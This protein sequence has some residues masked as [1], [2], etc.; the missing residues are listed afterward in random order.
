MSLDAQ[1][2]CSLAPG[3][4][5]AEETI[6]DAEQAATRVADLAEEALQSGTFGI[7]GLLMGLDGRVIAQARNAV[8]HG[9]SVF[10]P[11]AHVERQLVDWYFATRNSL[12]PPPNEIV[13]VSSLDP[14]AM[15][16]GAILKAGFKVIAV[17]EDP[18]SGIHSPRLKL[19]PEDT[20]KEI[21][22]RFRIFRRAHQNSSFVPGFP[23][24]L[25]GQISDVTWGRSCKAFLESLEHVRSLVSGEPGRGRPIVPRLRG[26]VE[27]LPDPGTVRVPPQHLDIGDV[28]RVP[29]E[30]LAVELEDN[31]SWLIDSFGKLLLIADSREQLSPSRSSI[32][33]LIRGYSRLRRQSP[34][35][36][37][38]GT[39]PHPRQCSVL[40]KHPPGSV[41]QALLDLGALGS[42]LE[43]RRESSSFPLLTVLEGDIKQ[44]ERYV[45]ALPTLYT[46]EI[47]VSVGRLSS[48]LPSHGAHVLYRT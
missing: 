35:I 43:G 13:I 4:E 3:V 7:G 42:F 29:V 33:E 47:G 26:S 31:Q 17:G 25:S 38:S 27:D 15:C 9:N 1:L 28:R 2:T 36:A 19:L 39:L 18:T 6:L 48:E 12:S 21:D 8:I 30:L 44:A 41:A 40:T 34:Q 46:D 20:R 5:P 32:L 24:Q 22:A 45:S 11:T 37:R 10:D 23:A 14:C 16:T